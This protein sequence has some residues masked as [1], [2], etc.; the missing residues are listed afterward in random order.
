MFQIEVSNSS[1]SELICAVPNMCSYYLVLCYTYVVC[2]IIYPHVL[3]QSAYKSG[4]CCF[5]GVIQQMNINHLV[6]AEWQVD[7]TSSWNWR[8]CG[9]SAQLT[10]EMTLRFPWWLACFNI[11]LYFIQ[12]MISTSIHVHGQLYKYILHKWLLWWWDDQ[13]NSRWP[14]C[15]L[16]WRKCAAL[17]QWWHNGYQSIAQNILQQLCIVLYNVSL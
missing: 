13:Q 9:I 6:A 2:N 14:M 4:W 12:K 11:Y 8:M 7:M 3:L 5:I 15:G 1:C 10:L 17:G 16:Q